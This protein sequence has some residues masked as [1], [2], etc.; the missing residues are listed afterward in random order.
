MEQRLFVLD[1]YF[2]FRKSLISKLKL[3]YREKEKNVY[4]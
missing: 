4:G 3:E 1:I 2:N